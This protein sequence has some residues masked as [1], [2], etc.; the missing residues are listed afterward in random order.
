M[1]LI[2]N[3]TQNIHYVE[4]ALNNGKEIFFPTEFLHGL[5][6]GGLGAGLDDQWNFMLSKPLSAGA[7]LWVFADEGVERRDKNDSID[8]WGNQAPDG[9]LG[10]YHEKE[11]SFLHCKR[12][13]VSCLF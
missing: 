7:F 3:I 13:M 2:Q 10:P 1:A 12:N 11:G 8:T 4:N 5:N 6:D 9:I